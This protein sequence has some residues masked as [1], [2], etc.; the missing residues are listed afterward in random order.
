MAW[1]AIA[2]FIAKELTFVT[3]TGNFITGYKSGADPIEFFLKFALLFL[4]ISG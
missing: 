4:V 3:T 2:A 1:V